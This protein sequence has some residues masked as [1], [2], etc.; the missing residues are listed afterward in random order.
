MASMNDSFDNTRAKLRG[1]MSNMMRMAK[2]TG[3]GW[4][5]WLLFICAVVFTFWYVW[6]F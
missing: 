1:T 2:R 5:A 6:L 4:K 3:V